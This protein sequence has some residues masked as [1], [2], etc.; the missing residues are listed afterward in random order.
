MNLYGYAGGDP[1][2]FSDPFGL[3]AKDTFVQCRDVG[4][5]GE[6]NAGHC[7]VRVVDKERNIDVTIELLNVGDRNEI[8]WHSVPGEA[9]AEGYSQSERVKVGVPE[10]MS[11]R[12]FDD[13]VL[14]SALIKSAVMRPRPPPIPPG[15]P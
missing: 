5:T 10:G 9:E 15:P 12:A 3:K 11:T 6:G 4:D 1:I 2:N 14:N 7:A 8:Y 13:L